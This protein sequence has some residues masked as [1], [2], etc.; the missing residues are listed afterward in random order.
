MISLKKVIPVFVIAALLSSCSSTQQNKA[1]YPEQN[2][3]DW[4][5]RSAN[6]DVPAWVEPALNNDLDNLPQPLQQKLKNKYF[7]VIESRRDRMDKASDAELSEA[8]RTAHSDYMSCIARNLN[9]A[10]DAYSKGSLSNNSK[11]KKILQ[12]SAAKAKFS[13]FTKVTESWVLTRAYN[14]KKKSNIDT[15][16]VLQ[17]YA[18]DKNTWLSQAQGYINNVCSQDKGNESLNEVAKHSRQIT[19]IILPSKATIITSVNVK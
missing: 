16:K 1:S 11:T 5:G 13:G 6:G 10:I 3:I 18:C 4:E 8:Q 15:Y 12:E 17:V 7:I 14:S 2:F 9:T 19:N